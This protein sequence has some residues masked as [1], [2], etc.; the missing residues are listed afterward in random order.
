VPVACEHGLPPACVDLAGLGD[1]L[2]N[3]LRLV[4]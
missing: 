4:L 1:R 2:V 3:H